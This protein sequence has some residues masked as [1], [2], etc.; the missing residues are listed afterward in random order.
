EEI[1]SEVLSSSSN[2]INTAYKRVFGQSKTK[3]P[4]ATLL[5]FHDLI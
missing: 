1:D 4:E 5:G 3:Y 2:T